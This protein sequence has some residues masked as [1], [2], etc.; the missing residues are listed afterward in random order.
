MSNTPDEPDETDDFPDPPP[1]LRLKVTMQCM[2]RCRKAVQFEA[3]HVG[4]FF[5]IPDMTCLR[6]MGR[7]TMLGFEPVI[8]ESAST[9]P[10]LVQ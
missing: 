5:Q 2:G 8:I 3:P 10:K 4:G 7:A 9:M 1:G 6:C